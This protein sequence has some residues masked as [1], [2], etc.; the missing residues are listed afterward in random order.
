MSSETQKIYVFG[1]HALTSDELFS[2]FQLRG[3]VPWR[4]GVGDSKYQKKKLA[5]DLRTPAQPPSW[6][7]VMPAPP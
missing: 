5:G 6:I 7:A 2:H 1:N 3:E 4:N